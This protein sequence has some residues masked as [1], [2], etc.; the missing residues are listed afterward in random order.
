V[1]QA[2]GSTPL[3]PNSTIAHGPTISYIR[4]P[5]EGEVETRIEVT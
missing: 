5:F 1:L 3:I 2:E 4:V